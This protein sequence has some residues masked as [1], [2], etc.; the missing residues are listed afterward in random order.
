MCPEICD[1]L[2]SFCFYI[3]ENRSSIAYSLY[4]FNK[5]VYKN[6]FLMTNIS[7]NNVVQQLDIILL[8]RLF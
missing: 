1:V 7:C 6:L 5:R 2:F 8:L 3:K 4:I